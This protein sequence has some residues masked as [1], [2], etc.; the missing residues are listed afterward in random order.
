MRGGKVLYGDDTVVGGLS[1]GCD[2][3][4]V[5]GASKQVCL[6]SEIGKNLAALQTAVGASIYPAFFCGRR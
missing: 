4:D 3:L 1:T 2:T 6:Q 5:C